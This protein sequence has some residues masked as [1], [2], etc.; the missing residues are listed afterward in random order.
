[1]IDSI[2]QRHGGTQQM[3]VKDNHGSGDALII[4]LDLARFIINF[5]YLLDITN[6]IEK[7]NIINLTQGDSP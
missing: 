4:P 7:I 6:E 1:M 2:S 3:M 5:R